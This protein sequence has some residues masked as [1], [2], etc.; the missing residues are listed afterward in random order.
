MKSQILNFV[1]NGRFMDYYGESRPAAETNWDFFELF[2]IED[3]NLV[4]SIGKVT[5][6]GI[7]A[8]FTM[9]SL[10]AFL[11]AMT[12]YHRGSAAELIRELNR[13]ICQI[14]PQTFYASLFHAWMEPASGR[15]RYVNAGQMAAWR[16]R[17][18]GSRFCRLETTGT[19]I[20]L[21]LRI[22]YRERSVELEPGDLL[23]AASDGVSE[24]LGEDN[25]L[26]IVR[27]YRHSQAANIVSGILESTD[28]ARDRTVVAVRVRDWG[29]RGM[30]EAAAA[31]LASFVR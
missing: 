4:C 10:Q 6:S 21:S 3:R 29:E 23:I 30:V 14:A 8:S 17:Q 22:G 25:I 18:N 31:K 24:T 7:A 12:P 19:V 20:G 13:T 1:H 26:D 5:G 27:N 2:P 11:H 16:I 9:A 15:L 28:P